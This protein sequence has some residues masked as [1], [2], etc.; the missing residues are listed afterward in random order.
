MA[1]LS[2]ALLA[3]AL[4]LCFAG[5]EPVSVHVFISKRDEEAQKIDGDVKGRIETPRSC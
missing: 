4:P 2:R 3:C 5:A 1:S